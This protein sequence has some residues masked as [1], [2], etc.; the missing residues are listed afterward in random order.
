[1][2]RTV[3]EQ[4]R[5]FG[6]FNGVPFGRVRNGFPWRVLAKVAEALRP[7]KSLRKQLVSQSLK[8]IKQ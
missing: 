3:H 8:L 6:A 1:M 7:W 5:G 4:V 2:S